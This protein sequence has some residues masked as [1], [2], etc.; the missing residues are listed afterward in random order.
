[1]K[2]RET[3]LKEMILRNIVQALLSSR[4][5]VIASVQGCFS[6]I[7]KISLSEFK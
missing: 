4:N 6:Q 5:I 7:L 1:M 3:A 2:S